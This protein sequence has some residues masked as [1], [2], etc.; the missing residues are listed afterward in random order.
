MTPAS[1]ILDAP[2]ESGGSGLGN[3][4]FVNFDR[5]MRREDDALGGRS[6]RA[7]DDVRAASQNGMAKVIENARSSA[8]ATIKLSLD[9]SGRR[10]TT[11]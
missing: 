11:V 7:T 4:C 9:C 2:S 1:I 8:S 10:R 5:R 3:K 6:N